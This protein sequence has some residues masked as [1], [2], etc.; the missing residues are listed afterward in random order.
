LLTLIASLALQGLYIHPHH[1]QRVIEKSGI[2]CEIRFSAIATL[3]RE[4]ELALELC[5]GQQHLFSVAFTFYSSDL[6]SC[7]GIGCLQDSRGDNTQGRVRNATRDMFGLRPKSLMVR[8]VRELGRAYGCKTLILMGNQ[9]RDLFHQIC[10]T[11]VFAD[12]GKFLAGN[13]NG[14]PSRWRIRVIL[15]RHCHS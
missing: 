2:V 1:D 11:Q 5:Y 3:D 10:T 4:G 8:L 14:L 6:V 13:G 9:N 7:I 15:R 12:Y